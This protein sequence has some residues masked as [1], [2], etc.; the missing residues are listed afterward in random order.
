M[1]LNYLWRG[2][3]GHP[4][5]PPLTD[6]TI[7]AYTFAFVAAVLS[8][9]GVSDQATAKAWWLALVVALCVSVPTVLTGLL[10][11]LA[12]SRGTP[13]YRTVTTHMLVMATAS[14]TF[15]LAA[16]FGHACYADGRITVG[17]LVLTIV[18]FVVLAVGGWLGGAITY[19]HGMRV[20]NLV[21]EPAARA[22]SPVPS[23]EEQEAD[24]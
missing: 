10:E 6:V 1:K 15:L 13:L 16:I 7:G 19:V 17:P 8:K 11:W 3:P 12:M 5:H 4:L 20:L 22:A 18:G 2:L 9:A 23:K 14:V 24:G 21:D